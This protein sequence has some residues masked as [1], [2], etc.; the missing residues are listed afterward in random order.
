MILELDTTLL[1]VFPSIN[2]NQLVFLTL[3]L[4]G[5][6]QNNQDVHLLLSRI[7]ETEIQELIDNGLIAVTTSGDNKIYESTQSLKDALKQD[8]TWFDYFYEV[9][10]VYVTRPDGTKGFLRSNINKC[11]KEYNRIVG[12]SKAMHEHIL[13][14]LKY[15]IDEKTITGKLGY[16][17]TMWKWLTQ[18]E[19]ESIEEQMNFDPIRY[20]RTRTSNDDGI[21]GSNVY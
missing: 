2:I 21:Y 8:K 9:F 4:N 19:W 14:C 10:P 3:V 16:M 12:K 6:N 1:E 11:R 17:K 5:N 18:R 15:E 7:S 13:D 20:E